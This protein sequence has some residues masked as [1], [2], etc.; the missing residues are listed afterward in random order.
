MGAS[1]RGAAS[2]SPLP[3]SA[4]NLRG[5]VRLWR[6]AGWAGAVARGSSRRNP[7]AP[8]ASLGPQDARTVHPKKGLACSTFRTPAN[9]TL[10]GAKH[11]PQD[12]EARARGGAQRASCAAV[13]PR[14]RAARREGPL[15]PALAPAGLHAAGGRRH[16]F[17]VQVQLPGLAPSEGRGGRADGCALAPG[18]RSAPRPPARPARLLLLSLGD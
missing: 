3:S 1:S 9:A 6:V 14:R 7:L 11:L 12:R 15:P 5:A 13:R 18:R 10:W 4:R 17:P 2:S 16:A 8:L